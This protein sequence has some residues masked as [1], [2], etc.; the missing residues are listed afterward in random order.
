MLVEQTK[1]KPP[2]TLEFKLNKQIE[3]FSFSPPKNLIEEDK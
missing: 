2:E 1:T 3:T